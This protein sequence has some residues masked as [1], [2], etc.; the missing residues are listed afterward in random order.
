MCGKTL[1]VY[2]DRKKPE[3]FK[4]RQV[5]HVINMGFKAISVEANAAALK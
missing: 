5:T 1:V 3:L 2:F 4:V